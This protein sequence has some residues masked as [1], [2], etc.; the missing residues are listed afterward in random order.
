LFALGSFA[1]ALSALGAMPFQTFRSRCYEAACR[2]SMGDQAGAKQAI[3]KALQ[4]HP[5]LRLQSFAIEKPIRIETRH[6]I[7]LIY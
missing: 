6:P 3:S 1:E 4:I 5:N 7:C 2:V